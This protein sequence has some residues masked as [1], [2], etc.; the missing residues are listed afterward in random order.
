MAITLKQRAYAGLWFMAAGSTWVL[1]LSSVFLS[2]PPPVPPVEGVLWFVTLPIVAN[3]LIGAL[4]GAYI[5]DSHRVR[6]GWL[7]AFLGLMVSVLGFL[8][9]ALLVSAREGY[10]HGS[11]SI[12]QSFVQMLFLML[13]VGSLAIGWM[14]VMIGGVAGWLLYRIRVSRLDKR[15]SH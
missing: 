1:S 2:G 6:S 7:A 12:E 10:W 13:L 15:G 8:C 4:L 9:Y 11:L 5:L 14:V 3:G